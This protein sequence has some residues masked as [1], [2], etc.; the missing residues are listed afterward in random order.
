[1][2]PIEELPEGEDFRDEEFPDE[3]EDEGDETARCPK[4]GQPIYHEAVRCPHCGEYVTPGS[5]PR[6]SWPWWVW[7]G[8]AL[9][10]A[11]LLYLA[12]RR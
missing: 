10:L 4:C 5:N 11:A 3:E 9:T 6:K 2:S 1:M 7:A 8:I 12:I